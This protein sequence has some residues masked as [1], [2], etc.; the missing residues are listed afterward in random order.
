MFPTILLQGGNWFSRCALVAGGHPRIEHHPSFELRH[1]ADVR[2]VLALCVIPSVGGGST[3]WQDPLAIPSLQC[4]RRFANERQT[5]WE[6]TWVPYWY[7]LT[8][9]YIGQN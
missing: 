9:T 1:D 3:S 5:V 4:R 6:S 2:Q 8:F 7:C